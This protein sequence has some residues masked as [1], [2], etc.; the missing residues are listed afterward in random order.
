MH[1]PF[2]VKARLTR[3]TRITRLLRDLGG[4]MAIILI[5]ATGFLLYCFLGMYFYDHHEEAE[6]IFETPAKVYTPDVQSRGE[7]NDEGVGEL[8]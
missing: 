1:I 6:V 3:L 2:I 4:V 5:I 8:E 7:Y